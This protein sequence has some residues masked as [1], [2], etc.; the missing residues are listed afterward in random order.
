[1]PS[2]NKKLSP[3]VDKPFLE[4]KTGLK[5][6]RMD[7]NESGF[8]QRT[9]CTEDP[10]IFMVAFI[11]L[12]RDTGSTYLFAYK[13]CQMGFFFQQR[14]RNGRTIIAPYYEQGSIID[15]EN[16]TATARITG[17][18]TAIFDADG[19]YH[20][21]TDITPFF[22][23]GSVPEPRPDLAEKGWGFVTDITWDDFNAG[24]G[25]KFDSHE[26]Q[27]EMLEIWLELATMLKGGGF[28]PPPNIRN[29][30]IVEFSEDILK[31]FENGDLLK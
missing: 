18:G 12:G 7:Y 20:G 29:R 25:E 26:Q 28:P 31:Q 27:A 11:N 21:L 16:H 24:N 1:M 6:W 3:P 13:G 10:E 2:Y 14:S 9:V 23:G 19:T 17:V 15:E 30:K 8:K 22:V 5:Y 4:T